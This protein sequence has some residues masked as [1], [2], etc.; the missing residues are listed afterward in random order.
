MRPNVGG[1]DRIIR[2]I[3][4]LIII[5]IGFYYHSWWGVIG[6]M[7][8]ATGLFR[9]CGLYPLLGISTCRTKEKPSG[10]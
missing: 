6:V 1:A 7:P 2:I 5:G 9:F 4:G 3:I 8:L 10:S